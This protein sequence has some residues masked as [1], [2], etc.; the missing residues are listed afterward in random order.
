MAA[1][2]RFVVADGWAGLCLGRVHL[3]DFQ[4]CFQNQRMK[5][6]G[7]DALFF[8]QSEGNPVHG[9]AE[10]VGED[11]R[12]M[13]LFPLAAVQKVDLLAEAGSQFADDG[14]CRGVARLQAERQPL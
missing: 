8:Q 5:Y 9:V 14:P 3:L 13:Q 7:V 6:S 1:H 2:H 12:H 11:T 4:G 10:I